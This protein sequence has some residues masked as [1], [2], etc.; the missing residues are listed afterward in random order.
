MLRHMNFSYFEC[1][2]PQSSSKQSSSPNLLR[3]IQFPL[4]LF[5]AHDKTYRRSSCL[6]YLLAPL[7]PRQYSLVLA[8]FRAFSDGFGILNSHL[9]SDI[10]AHPISI[11]IAAKSLAHSPLIPD[12]FVFVMVACSLRQCQLLFFWISRTVSHLRVCSIFMYRLKKLGLKAR[13]LVSL[14]QTLKL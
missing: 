3:E 9:P 5:Y 13:A 12:V 8:T 6:S 4:Q 2:L 14:L 7:L 1:Q 10:S 11:P